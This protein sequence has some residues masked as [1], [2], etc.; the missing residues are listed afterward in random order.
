MSSYNWEET[1][2]NEARMKDADFEALLEE[3]VPELPPA[4]VVKE[5]TPWK[6]AMNRILWGMGF[7]TITFNF[8]KLD[9]ILPFIGMFLMLFGFRVLREENKWFK[10][11]WHLMIIRITIFSVICILDATI[12]RSMLD[13][14]NVGI[15]IT[16]MN[17]VLIF[18]QIICF[19][20]AIRKT[21]EKAGLPQ[22]AKAAIVLLIWYGIMIILG[23]AQYAGLLV[24]VMLIGYVSIIRSLYKLSKELAEAGFVIQTAPIK[25]AEWKV[26]AGVLT[27]VIAGIS[28]GYL[29][30]HSY[31][32][33]WQPIVVSED[34]KVNEI[35]EHLIEIGFPKNV[36]ADLTEEDI[37]TCE[38]ALRVVTDVC[39][40]PVNDGNIVQEETA[41]GI[42]SEYISYN[43]KELR[44]THIAIEL[45]GEI[46]C[47]KV[48]HHFEF[49]FHPGFYGTESIQLWSTYRNYPNAWSAE[50]AVTGR[51]LYD[52]D[53][54]TFVAPYAS[55]K[56]ETYEAYNII[57]TSTSRSTDVFAEFSMPN[58]GSRQRGYV[59]YVT[60][61]QMDGCILASWINYTHQKNWLQYPV[62]TAKE[63]RMQND[64]I[65]RE[66]FKTIQDSISFYPFRE[67]ITVH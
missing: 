11:C 46:E 16:A 38:G 8:W 13:A 5:V 53:G 55:L 40:H 18:T 28:C 26:V 7:T 10:S 19:W 65:H 6:T 9:Y 25:V 2:K 30:F 64:W 1:M 12:I 36:L 22:R 49:I 66:P 34:A 56:E 17:F 59:S 20:K 27:I 37:L 31:P 32:M 63:K 29:F 15:A 57:F 24:F 21:Q 48:I 39:D 33:D 45:P 67:N 50:G 60:K 62:L 41:M 44:F 3:C 43:R 54:Q 42:Y 35:K 51:V 23:V 61:E 4:D 47:W 58:E 52:M 14:S